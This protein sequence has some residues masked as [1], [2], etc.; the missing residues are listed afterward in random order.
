MR[1][2]YSG[3][4]GAKNGFVEITLGPMLVKFDYFKSFLRGTFYFHFNLFSCY[5]SIAIVV[6]VLKYIAIKI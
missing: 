2:M 4:N 1:E 5:H 6:F 3:V